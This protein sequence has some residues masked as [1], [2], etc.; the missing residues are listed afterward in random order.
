M[1]LPFLLRYLLLD[2]TV[3]FSTGALI[4]CA[5]L[6]FC[7]ATLGFTGTREGLDVSGRSHKTFD[8]VLLVAMVAALL[9]FS[10]QGE[11]VTVVLLGAAALVYGVLV[12]FTRYT[13]RV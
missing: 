10:T 2:S 8:R 3:D 13:S 1:V 5:V 11:L 12:T 4:V 9:F 7:A 6:G